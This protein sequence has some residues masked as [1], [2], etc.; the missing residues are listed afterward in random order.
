PQCD[1]RGVFSW[2]GERFVVGR[3]GD[4]LDPAEHGGE[5][6]DGHPGDVVER[7]LRHEIAAEGVCKNL[8][9]H[10]LGILRAVLLLHQLRPDAP[11]AMYSLSTSFWMNIRVF[12][13]LTPCFSNVA[14]YI[15]AIIGPIELAVV[16]I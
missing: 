6:F 9:L 15:A 7:L 12:L 1:R 4:R 16:R 10:R 13:M 2:D 3:G 8:Q 5:R 14:M 11:R